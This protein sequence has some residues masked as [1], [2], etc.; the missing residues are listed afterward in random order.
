MSAEET[1]AQ[2]TV[3]NIDGATIQH[4]PLSN[5][6]YLM[7]LGSADAGALTEKL[8]ALARDKGYTKVFAKVPEWH[9]GPFLE[10]EYQVEASVPGFYGGEQKGLFL[11]KYFC[12][13]R[14]K[15]TA[16]DKLDEIQAL[17]LTKW[18][19]EPEPCVLPG[20]TALRVCTPNDVE[21]MAVIYK[22]VFPT[23]P[24]PINDP[25]YLRETME[26]HVVYFG[27]TRGEDLVALASAEMDQAASNVEMTDFAT[28]PR[29]RG[30]G[31]ALH[32]LTAMEREMAQRGMRTAFTIARA[33]SPGMN[34]TFA[35][36][37][38]VF[39]GRL[40]N[41]TNIAGTIE[42]MNVWHKTL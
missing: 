29:F 24:F 9:G 10:H 34:I 4:G 28:L 27:V 8:D 37:G 2:D 11:A 42:S 20:G 30:N 32:L 16:P 22:E 36:C 3:E 23:Y 17:A 15:E 21:A 33:V 14:A 35:K 6:I 18:C 40:V 12:S 1:L 7:K 5:R 26:T 13:E 19:P 38:Y 39:G 31:Y 41:N 25:A